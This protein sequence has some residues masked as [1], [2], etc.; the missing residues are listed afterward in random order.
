MRAPRIDAA[1]RE[2]EIRIAEARALIRR[3]RE[4]QRR[5]ARPACRMLVNR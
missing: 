5:P 4:K 1:I 3:L 2:L